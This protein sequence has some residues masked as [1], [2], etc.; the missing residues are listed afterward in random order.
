MTVGVIVEISMKA[1]G[2]TTPNS[3][4]CMPCHL[5][6]PMNGLSTFAILI[7]NDAV[8]AGTPKKKKNTKSTFFPFIFTTTLSNIT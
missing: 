8:E 6:F 3:T 4:D 1:D 5:P 7:S 2:R